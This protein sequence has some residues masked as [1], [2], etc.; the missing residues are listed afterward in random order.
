MD[1]ENEALIIPSL[2]GVEIFYFEN[3]AQPSMVD[4]RLQPKFG[5]PQSV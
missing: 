5:L 4:D 2:A 3:P 1:Y